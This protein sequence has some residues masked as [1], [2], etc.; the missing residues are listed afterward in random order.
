MTVSSDLDIVRSARAGRVDLVDVPPRF[1]LSV[2]GFGSPEG[3][4][5]QNA[6][7]TLMPMAWAIH[8][9][10]KHDYGVADHHVAHLEALWWL[11]GEDAAFSPEEKSLWC[12]EAFVA[13]SEDVPVALLYR[14]MR[15]VPVAR[16]LPS[17]GLLEM[18]RFDEG[19]S[20]QTLHVGSY[21]SE[22]PT[23]ALLGEFMAAYDLVPDGRHHEIYLSDAHRCDPQRLHTILRQ[24]VRHG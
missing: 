13:E 9:G 6:V 5:F 23:I 20:V 21:G 12:W 3:A 14:L 11:D 17:A 15:D 7:A 18:R 10:L 16:N 22:G 8:A 1:I 4:A 2:T 19:L 24:P